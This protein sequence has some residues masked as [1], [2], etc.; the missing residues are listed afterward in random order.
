VTRDEDARGGSNRQ[1][2][3][4]GLQSISAWEDHRWTALPHLQGTERTDVCVIGLGG[5]GLSAIEVLLDHGVNVIGIDASQVAGGAAGAN[6]GFLLAGNARFYHQMLASVGRDA[7]RKL[8]LLTVQEI[9]RMA[10]E[11]P[12]LV[13][14][15]GSLRIAMSDEELVNCEE[16]FAGMQNDGLPVERY[17]GPEGQGLLIPTDGV[18]NPLARCRR[19]AARCLQ[20]GANRV[21]RLKFAAASCAQLKE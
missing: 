21:Q 12:D 6:G 15:V 5:S 8:Y 2:T 7:A 17:N 10:L 18:F 16:Q 3:A 20:R 4:Y 1:P 14:R 11:M 19:L 9:E 13:R